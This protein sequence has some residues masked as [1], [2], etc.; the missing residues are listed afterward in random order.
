MKT[1]TLVSA[2]RKLYTSSKS[3]KV[4]EMQFFKAGEPNLQEIIFG[5]SCLA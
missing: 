3:G 2:S 4:L 5:C 1:K